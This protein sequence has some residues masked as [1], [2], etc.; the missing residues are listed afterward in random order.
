MQKLH[1]LPQCIKYKMFQV[2]MASTLVFQNIF[3]CVIM[4]VCG[5]VLF[6]ATLRILRLT[7]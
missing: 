6:L 2:N 3:K 5:G 4:C 1:S 7:D